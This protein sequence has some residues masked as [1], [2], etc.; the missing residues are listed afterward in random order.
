MKELY[1]G[2]HSALFPQL[3]RELRQEM[4]SRAQTTFLA[5]QRDI[6]RAD[7]YKLYFIQFRE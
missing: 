1:M 2:P 7:T 3:T 4:L 6:N 5:I